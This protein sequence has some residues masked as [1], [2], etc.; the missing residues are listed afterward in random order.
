MLTRKIVIREGLVLA[1]VIA[2]M[3]ASPAIFGNDPPEVGLVVVVAVAWIAIRLAMIRW[4]ENR[5]QNSHVT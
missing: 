5:R 3:Y 2:I 4:V 1:M